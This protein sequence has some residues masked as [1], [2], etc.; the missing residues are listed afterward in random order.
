MLMTSLLQVRS[1]VALRTLRLVRLRHSLVSTG[2]IGMGIIDGQPLGVDEGDAATATLEADVIFGCVFLGL[3]NAALKENV[4]L[5]WDVESLDAL[6][7]EKYPEKQSNVE[8]DALDLE[9]VLRRLQTLTGVKGAQIGVGESPQYNDNTS[10]EHGAINV[11]IAART[12]VAGD[13]QPVRL[14]PPV[15]RFV[16]ELLDNKVLMEHYIDKEFGA[17]YGIVDDEANTAPRVISSVRRLIAHDQEGG[18][19]N[20]GVPFHGLIGYDDPARRDTANQARKQAGSWESARTIKEWNGQTAVCGYCHG[21]VWAI[22]QQK[23]EFPHGHAYEMGLGKNTHKLSSCFGCSTFQIANDRYP[24]SMHLGRSD[25][26]VPLPAFSPFGDNEDQSEAEQQVF[27]A[28]NQRWAE[29]VSGWLRLG[30]KRVLDAEGGV[31]PP[32]VVET[33]KRL[34]QAVGKRKDAR[35][36]ANLFLDA[37]TVH[38]KDLLRLKRFAGV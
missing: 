13:A 12:D 25:S 17:Y 32:P 10:D 4:V 2:D 21:M 19:W 18:R 6:T 11:F 31:F 3:V 29:H 8:R 34:E 22:A 20:R 7:S 27:A 30:L 16:R 26:W 23:R 35:A 1:D 9:R 37:L 24:S 36:V 15:D 33:G 28:L 38:D 5:R 14:T